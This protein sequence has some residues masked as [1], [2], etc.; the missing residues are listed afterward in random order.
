MTKA[1]AFTIVVIDPC[2]SPVSIIPS[3]LSDQEYTITQNKFTYQVPVYTSDPSWCEITYS[4]TI[5]DFAGD[6]AV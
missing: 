6:A 1:N 5:T 4:Y 2:D 3:T